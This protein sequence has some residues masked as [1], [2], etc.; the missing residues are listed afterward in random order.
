MMAGEKSSKRY[1]DDSFLEKVGER[2]RQLMEEKKMTHEAFY[3]D[4][5]V[6]PHRILEGKHNITV[7]TLKRICEHLDITP[8]EFLKPIE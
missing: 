6:N 1:R 2:M 7:S 4:T 8:S 5:G 3:M